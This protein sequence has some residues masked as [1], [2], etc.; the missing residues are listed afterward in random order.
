[1]A[2]AQETL[3]ELARI[4]LDIAEESSEKAARRQPR[5]DQFPRGSS[6]PVVAL[7]HPPSRER[8]LL[9]FCTWRTPPPRVGGYVTARSRKLNIGTGARGAAGRGE[10]RCPFLDR[11]RA[12]LLRAPSAEICLSLKFESAWSVHRLPDRIQILR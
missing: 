12:A 11:R 5:G 6:P 8:P 7:P 4:A 9:I 1:M 3:H 2:T 10:G